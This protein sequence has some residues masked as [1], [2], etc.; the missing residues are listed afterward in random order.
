MCCH[1]ACRRCGTTGSWG[2]HAPL[3]IEAVRWLV[4]L[5]NSAQFVLLAA[6]PAD[7]PL[8]PARRCAEC[9]G[10]LRVVA[11]IPKRASAIHD[12]S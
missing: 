8:R 3:S 4:T 1:T 9:S 2:A 11:I 6:T 7:V 12:T 10:Q 5:Q